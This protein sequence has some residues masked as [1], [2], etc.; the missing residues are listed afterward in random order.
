MYYYTVKGVNTSGSSPDSN[1]AFSC[2]ASHY[3]LPNYSSSQTTN[4]Y[5]NAKD[6][7]RLAVS[8]GQ[9]I[10]ITWQDGNNQ[11]ASGYLRVSAWQNDGTSIFNEEWGGNGY[12]SP[13]EF[14]VTEAG[15]VTVEV[16]NI[17]GSTGYDYQ[18]Y[19]SF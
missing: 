11:N 9:R 1:M 15:Y 5:S 2:A 18:I 16:K 19:Y 13:R 17:S 8:T 14:T 7:Y 4:L 12:T 6:Y 10:T 3:A